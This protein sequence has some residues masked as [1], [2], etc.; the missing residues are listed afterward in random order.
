MY[1]LN[2]KILK[3]ITAHALHKLQQLHIDRFSSH[4]IARHVHNDARACI[5]QYCNICSQAQDLSTDVW[6]W[7]V[8]QTKN[9]SGT[10]GSKANGHLRIDMHMDM[11]VFL[12]FQG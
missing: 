3:R 9:I 11:Y 10:G 7:P 1:V 12:V 2:L 8:R 4:A 5:N 6:M